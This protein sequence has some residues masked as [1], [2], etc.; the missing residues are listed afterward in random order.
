MGAVLGSMI[1]RTK[2]R[3][4]VYVQNIW[5]VMNWI[6]G[7]LLTALYDLAPTCLSH[8]ISS[9]HLCPCWFGAVPYTCQHCCL[10]AFA[11]AISLLDLCSPNSSESQFSPSFRS[12]FKKVF[13]RET[14]HNSL[15]LFIY[16]CRISLM[17]IYLCIIRLSH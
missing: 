2:G 5:G 3:P 16:S 13:P 7:H 14:P 9:P 1:A 11:P 6:R 10:R 15:V 17:W 4:W 12:L 8:L